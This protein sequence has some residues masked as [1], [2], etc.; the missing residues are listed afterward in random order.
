MFN[1]ERFKTTLND[2]QIN[3]KKSLRGEIDANTEV[4]VIDEL[5]SIYKTMLTRYREMADS[6]STFPAQPGVA[7]APPEERMFRAL[8][9]FV[10]RMELDFTQKFVKDF[11]HGL[12]KEVEIGKIKISFLDNI[13]RGLKL[14]QGAQ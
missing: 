14:A 2:I 3:M 9:D 4:H 11:T 7:E 10:E 8:E 12:D 5:S 6:G 13:R 1:D